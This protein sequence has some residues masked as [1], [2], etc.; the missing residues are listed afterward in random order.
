MSERALDELVITVE[1]DVAAETAESYYDLYVDTFGHLATRAVARQLLHREEF[2][3]EMQD[4]RVHKY[5]AWDDAGEAIGMSTLTSQLETVPWISPDYFAH[6]YPEETARGAVYYLGFTLVHRQRRQ[7][8][9]FNAMVER[10]VRLLVAERA[11]CAWDICLHNDQMLGLGEN[12]ERILHR[13]ADVTV[14][15]I[16][17]QTYYAG[18]FHGPLVGEQAP[19]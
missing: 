9:I 16:D 2:L 5:V 3:E 13:C 11:V 17:R 6:R 15:P 19:W 1:T 18:R 12:I 14:A 8:R 4:P 10:I 7:T